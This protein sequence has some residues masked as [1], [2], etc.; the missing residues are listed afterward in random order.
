MASVQSTIGSQ[1][2]DFGVEEIEFIQL[3]INAKTVAD[4]NETPVPVE[5]HGYETLV[6][7]NLPPFTKKALRERLSSALQNIQVLHY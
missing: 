5:W 2:A 6:Q 4:I 3:L 1:F 7:P